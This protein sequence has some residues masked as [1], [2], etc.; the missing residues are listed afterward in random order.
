MN[1]DDPLGLKTPSPQSS[2][3]PLGLIGTPTAPHNP[4][5][6]EIAKRNAS[7]PHPE[8]MEDPEPSYAQKAL[9]GLASLGKNIPGVEAAQAG[10]RSFFQA[11]PSGASRFG[12]V[13]TKSDE[14]YTD[15]LSNIRQGESSSGAVGKMNSVIGGTVA[16]AATPGKT[17]FQQGALFGGAGGLLGADPQSAGDRVWNTAKG[18]AIGG[19][20]GKVLG[21]LAPNVA[22][23]IAAKTLGKNVLQRSTAMDAADAVNFSKAKGEGDLAAASPTPPAVSSALADTDVRPYVNVVRASGL[24]QNA[25]DPTVLRE[26]YKLMGEKER[27]LGS[28]IVGSD[29]YKAGSELERNE[30]I[31]GKRQLAQAAEPIMPSFGPANL[32]H[33]Q[34][35]GGLDAVKAGADATGR[36]LSGASIPGKKIAANSREQFIA[37][38]LEKNKT[39]AEATRQ[40]VL[41]QIQ[42]RTG[43][44]GITTP[45]PIKGFGLPS[46]A[47]QVNKMAPELN[48]LDQQAGQTGTWYGNRLRRG[49]GIALG[50]EAS[51]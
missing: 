11:K 46:S 30:I 40:G 51:Q 48:A 16:A 12:F 36:I 17:A 6:L 37:S 27:M 20:T 29:D 8:D 44:T 38:I 24:F 23:V 1:P 18:A 42:A 9:G 34:A 19:T 43:R 7:M 41:G 47:W 28:R 31:Q 10:A 15:A 35:E 45:N 3:D 33:A 50:N 2:A 21:E 25:D 13:P 39:E 14:S 22:R 4:T 5:K 32:A 26:A 49:L